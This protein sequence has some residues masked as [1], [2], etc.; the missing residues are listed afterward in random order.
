MK[1][2]LVF[3]SVV[4]LIAGI[5]LAGN[6]QEVKGLSD[7]ELTNIAANATANATA[8][9]MDKAKDVISTTANATAKATQTGIE[10]AKSDMK[11]LTAANAT[12]NATEV[13]K[14]Y[15]NGSLGISFQYPSNWRQLTDDIGLC[16]L[17]PC[18]L[19]VEFFITVPKLDT[20]TNISLN[21]TECGGSE[22]K[23]SIEVAILTTEKCDVYKMQL[24]VYGLDKPT[25]I[26]GHAIATH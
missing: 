25:S 6:S 21:S 11:T 7:L 1:L 23:G 13:L 20:A 12:A 16:N 4:F 17:G 9:A 3:G 5:T 24:D 19:G 2:G 22:P 18:S 26:G 14:K 8:A 10:Q 15:E